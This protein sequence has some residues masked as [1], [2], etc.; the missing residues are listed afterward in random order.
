MRANFTGVF[1]GDKIQFSQKAL[2]K[3]DTN[4]PGD[5]LVGAKSRWTWILL[6]AITLFFA[7]MIFWGFYGSMAESV[8][9]VG[10]TMLSQ[11][12][13]PI[14]ASFSGTISHL[15]I[16]GGSLVQPDQ[17]VGQIY[18]PE[19]F[20]RVQRLES[21]YALLKSQI[22]LLTVELEAFTEKLLLTETKKKDLLENLRTQNEESKKRAHEIAEIHRKLLAI[23]VEPK[24]T[25][26]QSLDQRLRAESALISTLLQ[27]LNSDSENEN[28]L[29]N[30]QQELLTL[31]QKL[32]AKL[33]DLLLA[34]EL[35][36]EAFWLR[37][38]F[39]GRVREVFKEEGA[40][41][42]AGEK[43]ALIDSN[44][45][46]GIYLLAFI[47]VAEAKKIKTGMSGFFSPSAIASKDYGFLRCVVREISP[48]AVNVESIQAELMNMS[49]TQMIAGKT[50]MVR[51]AL[52]LIPDK[53][54]RTK[55]LW[56]SKN[57]SGIPIT[58]GMVGSI[59]INTQYRSPASYIIPGIRKLFHGETLR[60]TQEPTI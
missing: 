34:R 28:I 47:N 50:T 41:V 10:V 58:G 14:V 32:D 8:S 1:M 19:Q 13:R 15:N 29:W 57:E 26:Y 37:S 6:W 5:V 7:A 17:I 42:Q 38:T 59:M 21:E 31:T 11:G 2:E 33:H 43:I 53:N 45:Q 54:S 39:E 51:V 27:N 16:K 30:R 35:Y 9:G 25:Y 49:L 46:D 20:F 4:A 22:E 56:T 23:S 3:N 48:L 12:S 24:V 60:E 40:F 52:E 18:N 44:H 55:F 36:N